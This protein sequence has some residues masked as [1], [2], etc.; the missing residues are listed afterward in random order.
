MGAGRNIIEGS[1][2]MT[3]SKISKNKRII[4]TTVKYPKAKKAAKAK[5]PKVAKPKAPGVIDTII[6]VLKDGGG[7]IT[8][9]TAKVAKK[10]PDRKAEQLASTVRAQMNR[11]NLPVE[12]GGRNLKVKK[13]RA[14]G[15]RQVNYTL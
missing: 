7:T 13:A 4:E 1:F 11:L 6:A 2:N 15:E 8:E 5:T 12:D 10:F 3:K 9:I 14:E